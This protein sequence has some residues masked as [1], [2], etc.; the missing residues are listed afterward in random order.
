MTADATTVS[1]GTP[2]LLYSAPVDA[3]DLLSGISPPENEM[4]MSRALL[5]RNW[6]VN[7]TMLSI[8]SNELFRMT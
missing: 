5:F 1:P 8:A 3:M 7:D 2:P 6:P 4:A